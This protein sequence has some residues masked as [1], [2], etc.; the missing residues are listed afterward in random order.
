MGLVG[1]AAVLRPH[2]P[3]ALMALML[4]VIGAGSGLFLTP[5][6]TSIMALDAFTAGCR[7]TLPVLGAMTVVG[8]VA[9]ARRNPPPAGRGNTSD[10]TVSAVAD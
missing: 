4:F 2:L 1:L 6:T 10:E 3:Y 9:S 8:M 7:T 5:N